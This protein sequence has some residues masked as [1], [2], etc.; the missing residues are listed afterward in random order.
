MSGQYGREK[1]RYAS[2]AKLGYA[3]YI[4]SEE[5]DRIVSRIMKSDRFKKRVG[6]TEEENKECFLNLV[7]SIAMVIFEEVF[8]NL[9]D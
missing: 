5:I 9:E 4:S 6:L 7:D 2:L 3:N 1:N 8:R